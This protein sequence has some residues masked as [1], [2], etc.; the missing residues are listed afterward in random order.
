MDSP[1]LTKTDKRLSMRQQLKS[2]VKGSNWAGLVRPKSDASRPSASSPT[3]AKVA[4]LPAGYDFLANG[5][6][7]TNRKP[8][9]ERPRKR[10]ERQ[11]AARVD[12][13]RNS[14]YTLQIEEPNLDDLRMSFEQGDDRWSVANP[15]TTQ[16]ELEKELAVGRGPAEKEVVDVDRP[17]DPLEVPGHNETHVGSESSIAPSRVDSTRPESDKLPELR[18]PARKWEV[19]TDNLARPVSRATGNT[20]ALKVSK[21]IESINKNRY[22][23]PVMKEKGH[24]TTVTSYHNIGRRGSEMAPEVVSP[25]VDEVPTAAVVGPNNTKIF[26]FLGIAEV[27]KP[28]IETTA[29]P[30]LAPPSSTPIAESMRKP[31]SL[32]SNINENLRR[33]APGTTSTLNPNSDRHSVGDMDKL[34]EKDRESRSPNKKQPPSLNIKRSFSVGATS[35]TKKADTQPNT[36]THRPRRVSGAKMADRMAWIRELE[37]KSSGKGSPGRAAMYKNLQGGVADKLARFESSNKDS[38]TKLARTNSATSRKSTLNDAY[39]IE[40]IVGKRLS[41]AST[42]DDE[43]RRK[44]EEVAQNTK[45][46]IDKEG[47]Q[48]ALIAQV[49]RDAEL[50]LR[51]EKRRSLKMESAGPFKYAFNDK[52]GRKT[53]LVP[54]P[55]KTAAVS[56][57]PPADE[58]DLKSF[59]P[60]RRG[61]TKMPKFDVK[62]AN[63]VAASAN[64]PTAQ[65]EEKIAAPVFKLKESKAVAAAVI[66]PVLTEPQVDDGEY[67]PFNVLTY[68]VSKA[69]PS[70]QKLTAAETK[71]QNSSIAASGTQPG[72]EAAEEA[73]VPKPAAVNAPQVLEEPKKESDEKSTTHIPALE[74]VEVVKFQAKEEP[75]V[76]TTEEQERHLEEEKTTLAAE[77]TG[78]TTKE[79]KDETGAEVATVVQEEKSP[80]PVEKTTSGASEETRV[81]ETT[82]PTPKIEAKA[83]A[84]P[85]EP[86]ALPPSRMADDIKPETSAEPA[87]TQAPLVEK[88]TA[89]PEDTKSEKSVEPVTTQS[90][91]AEKTKAVLEDSTSETSTGPAT[92][93]APLA[94]KT[95]AVPEDTKLETSAEPV[96]TQAPSP[97]ELPSG[98]QDT[99]PETSTKSATA[100]KT[101]SSVTK[102]TAAEIPLINTTPPTPPAKKETPVPK[103]LALRERAQKAAE[104]S[105]KSAPAPA[106]A[107]LPPSQT[108]S[109]LFG[110]PMTSGMGR[111]RSPSPGKPVGRADVPGKKEDG[112]LVKKEADGSAKKEAD[113]PVKKEADVPVKKEAD[114]PVKK[115]ADVPAK[116]E[117]DV[118]AK[119]E[120]DVPA[121]KEATVSAKKGADIPAEKEAEAKEEK[122]AKDAPTQATPST[123]KPA[124][125]EKSLTQQPEKK[126]LISQETPIVAAKTSPLNGNVSGTESKSNALKTDTPNDRDT[127]AEKDSPIKEPTPLEKAEPAEVADGKKVWP[128]DK[129][130]PV[131]KTEVLETATSIP[132]SKGTSARGESPTRKVT[133]FPTSMPGR[134]EGVVKHEESIREEDGAFKT[135]SSGLVATSSLAKGSIAATSTPVSKPEE[136]SSPLATLPRKD[137]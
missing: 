84:L 90:S 25:L 28:A 17:I 106:P 35:P 117:A 77:S 135:E 56:T 89:V 86:I 52:A 21:T 112:V 58:V 92:T 94:E 67:D 74:P 62:D 130:A 82:Q 118:P 8:A 12:N 54:D 38:G 11:K 114:V 5:L 93:Q 9:R 98:Q 134:K 119:K 22:S 76:E 88:I 50:A 123:E 19:K 18:K 128:I 65:G 136:I 122:L 124:A 41:K 40:S 113:V 125:Q 104:I 29:G 64:P 121:K 34:L 85:V 129:V 7:S 101:D 43:F 26:G 36:P 110:P 103:Y 61:S 66:P 127:S 80:R 115:E 31:S 13:Q 44:M 133:P 70:I 20:E 10:Q 3:K 68:P 73:D 15:A 49:N 1:H 107:P 81:E 71:Q 87:T 120:A 91:S 100:S 111:S 47:D 51:E 99:K 24:T 131:E 96:T 33:V 126:V 55:K 72:D 14:L 37:E 30:S 42:M 46:K 69:M 116:K 83:L 78:I 2:M 102:E 132:M 97:K 60:T 63:A 39:G 23:M 109:R 4:D 32:T 6:P 75:T 95:T 45:K 137:D 57:T 16:K 79:R 53:D 108:F 105:S 27:R 48:E 59:T